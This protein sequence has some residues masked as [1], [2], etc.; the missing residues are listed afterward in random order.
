VPKSGQPHDVFVEALEDA[1]WVVERRDPVSGPGAPN[2]TRL[3]IRH[4]QDWRRLLVYA[5]NITHEGKGRVGDNYRTQ[6]T[7]SHDGPLI[8]EPDRATVGIGW[9]ESRQVFSAYDGWTKRE[10]GSSSA[11]HIKRD[12]L[13]DAAATGWAEEGP[14]WDARACFTPVNVGRF[15]TWI[16]YMSARREAALAPLEFNLID[17]DHAEIVGDIWGGQPT[18]WLR[19]RDRIL[20][21]DKK[22]ALADARL[23]R[24]EGLKSE[25]VPTASGRYNRTRVHFT[26]RRVGAIHD[27]SVVGLLQ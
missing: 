20:V 10:T 7:R 21:V 23:W 26:C 4:A 22:G 25:A 14:R 8:S 13:D 17:K 19:V 1:G 18:G 5:W 9:D 3:D 11:V 6:S 15:L 27:P 16:G 12:T 24:V 2:P